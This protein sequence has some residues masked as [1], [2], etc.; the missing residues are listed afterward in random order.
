MTSD[1]RS[2]PDYLDLLAGLFWD[3]SNLTSGYS[4]DVVLDLNDYE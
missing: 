2:V 4:E 3:Y 1:L